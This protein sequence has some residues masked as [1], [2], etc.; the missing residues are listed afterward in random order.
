MQYLFSSLALSHSPSFTKIFQSLMS[1]SF[2]TV[3]KNSQG[4]RVALMLIQ[5]QTLAWS[6]PVLKSIPQTTCWASPFPVPDFIFLFFYLN[7]NYFV[8]L[9]IILYSCPPFSSSFQRNRNPESICRWLL[10]FASG[11]SVHKL[12]DG[13]AME[14]NWGVGGNWGVRYSF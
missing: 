11:T 14:H 5:L 13:G 7:T 12:S 10:S 6:F 8:F 3:L 4:H 2:S 9:P 1:L